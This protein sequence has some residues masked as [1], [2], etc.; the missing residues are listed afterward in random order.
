MS[1]VTKTAVTV[2]LLLACTMA[3]MVSIDSVRKHTETSDTLS[4]CVEPQ[5]KAITETPI[6]TE[7]SET[8]NECHG[9]QCSPNAA[10]CDAPHTEALA[11]AMLE[12][13]AVN[14]TRSL[15]EV[16]KDTL[17]EDEQ[18]FSA[19]LTSV[20]PMM[21]QVLDDLS[22]AYAAKCNDVPTYAHYHAFAKI[23]P[24]AKLMAM[25]A[26]DTESVP[27]NR[28]PMQNTYVNCIPHSVKSSAMT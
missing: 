6:N 3:F 8:N 15:R 2:F 17:P 25:M 19:A 5:T 18:A 10:Q 27:L 11:N 4:L 1:A 7:V 14:T 12:P 22:V 23:E 16:L 21:G 26:V 24:T 20:S 28:M 9:E 13:D